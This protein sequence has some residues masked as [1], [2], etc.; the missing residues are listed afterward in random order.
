MDLYL[1][2]KFIQ[3]QRKLKKLTQ[4]QLAEKIGVSEKTISKWECGYGFPDSSLILPL[5]N[6]LE[7][8][9][10][11]LLSGRKLEDKEYQQN[12][13]DNILKLLQEKKASKKKLGISI[14]LA[15]LTLLASFTLFLVS[16]LSEMPDYLR[17]ILIIIGFIVLFVGLILTCFID[18]DYG[19]Y[20]C[21]N[22]G[23][24]FVPSMTQY[25]GAMHSLTTRHLK[26]PHCGKRTW[27][28][29]KLTK[30]KIDNNENIDN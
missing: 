9:A 27:A 17:V 28:K 30:E 16:G 14:C 4:L 10:N 26:C 2:G 20:E 6:V 11:E 19:S 3:E 18:N 22:C 5:C 12:A 24:R 8:S 13:E 29:R 1:I 7:I 15:V 25:I 21:R 23:E